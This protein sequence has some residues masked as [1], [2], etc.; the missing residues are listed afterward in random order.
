MFMIMLKMKNSFIMTI[1]K[2]WTASLMRNRQ[3]NKRNILFIQRDRERD[4]QLL[5]NILCEVTRRQDL[6]QVSERVCR[7]HALSTHIDI[8]TNVHDTQTTTH[9]SKRID[10]HIVITTKSLQLKYQA[11]HLMVTC[12]CT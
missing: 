11:L 8:H 1:S 9:A 2:K 7:Q 5:T 4:I 3:S 6:D 10:S 12:L